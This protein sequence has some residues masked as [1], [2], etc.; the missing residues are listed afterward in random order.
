[1]R[2]NKEIRSDTRIFPKGKKEVCLHSTIA[3]LQVSKEKITAFLT[4]KREISI[5][6]S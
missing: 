1:M 4:D 3:S 5:P 2:T 6:T